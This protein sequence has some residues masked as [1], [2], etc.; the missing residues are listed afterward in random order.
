VADDLLDRASAWGR[1][2]DCERLGLSVDAE[3]ERARAFYERR[4]LE[5]R[6]LKLDRSL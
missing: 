5:L 2:R 6:R 4:G 3:N 1:E